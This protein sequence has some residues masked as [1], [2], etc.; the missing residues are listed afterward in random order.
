MQDKCY[1]HDRNNYLASDKLK[2]KLVG[3]ELEN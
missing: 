2:A 3:N 1:V